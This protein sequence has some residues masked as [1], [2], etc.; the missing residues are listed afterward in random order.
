MLVHLENL[1]SHFDGDEELIMELLEVFAESYIL[2]L[3]S[4]NKAVEEKN[5]K[6]VELHAH[7]MKGMV[8][9]FFAEELKSSAFFLEKGGR[10]ENVLDFAT[11][12]KKLEDDIPVMIDEVKAIGA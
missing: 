12:L 7:T 8:A 2:V 9:N 4:L 3:E 10:E 11:H 5:Y 1:K 6:E